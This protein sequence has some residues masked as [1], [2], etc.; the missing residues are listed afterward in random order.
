[1]VVTSAA[2]VVVCLAVSRA[3]AKGVQR[4]APRAG[5]KAVQWVVLWAD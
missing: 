2:L 1:M 5:G 3:N 4:A